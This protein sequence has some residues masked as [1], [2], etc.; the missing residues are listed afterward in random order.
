MKREVIS[1]QIVEYV[2][3][4]RYCM[5]AH[6]LFYRITAM[7]MKVEKNYLTVLHMILTIEKMPRD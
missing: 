7:R 4:D 5:R 3:V 1:G 2:A 6:S